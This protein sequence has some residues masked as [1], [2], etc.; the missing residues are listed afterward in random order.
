MS[1]PLNGGTQEGRLGWL[2]ITGLAAIVLIGYFGLYLFVKVMQPEYLEFVITLG[3][4]IITIAVIIVIRMIELPGLRKE[5]AFLLTEREELCNR[6][7]EERKKIVN[8]VEQKYTSLVK[9]SVPLMLSARSLGL[10]HIHKNRKE[11]QPDIDKAIARTQDTLLMTGV[12]FHETYN[13]ENEVGSIT[14]KVQF[15]PD[16]KARF[17]LLNPYTTGAVLR[18]FLETDP[19]EIEDYITRKGKAFVEHNTLYADWHRAFAIFSH[20]GMKD[21]VRFY[22]C[23]PAVWLVITDDRVFVEPYTFGRPKRVPGEVVVDWRMGGH[24]PVF[25]FKRDSQVAEILENHFERLWAITRDGMCSGAGVKDL[26]SL[27]GSE[28]AS[29]E[30]LNSE[31]FNVRMNT[32]DTLYQSLNNGGAVA[33]DAMQTPSPNG[34]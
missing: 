21:R 27:W 28:D 23:D 5:R 19:T 6:L 20:S 2:A 29:I 26:H 15:N 3:H 17:L 11:A 4:L 16:I 22:R 12:A 25:E 13:I 1:E 18:A 14:K 31:V 8:D 33:R 9:E 30:K 24:M 34:N 32:L 7:L 10:S